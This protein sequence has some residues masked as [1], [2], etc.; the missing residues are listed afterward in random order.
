MSRINTEKQKI[1]CATETVS[2]RRGGESGIIAARTNEGGDTQ[3]I[4]FIEQETVVNRNKNQIIFYLNQPRKLKKIMDKTIILL[5]LK[6]NT[7][8]L[9]DLTKHYV[10]DE[11]VG[12]YSKV[13]NEELN[14]IKTLLS[15]HFVNTKF[16]VCKYLAED[17]TDEIVLF[18]TC[19]TTHREQ[20]H[21]GILALYENLKHKIYNTQLKCIVTK[22]SNICDICCRAKY[23]RQPIKEK[24]A[25]TEMPIDKNQIIHAD[26]Y[27]NSKQA[28]IVLIHKF[29]KFAKMYTL[30]NR[31]NAELINNL[32]I[33]FSLK[34]P[35]KIIVDN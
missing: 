32:K 23:D 30:S 24:F 5:N 35:K 26:T 2:S 21:P 18:E 11:T 4:T 1:I 3:Q 14:F 34:K 29:S 25:R 31:S 16:I 8:I 9:T 13:T 22:V 6:E 19:K 20:G 7:N 10:T 33:Y 28:F 27:V 15:N 17:I 12:V